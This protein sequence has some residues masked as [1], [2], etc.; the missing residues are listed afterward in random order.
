MKIWYIK[1]SPLLK[2]YM[3]GTVA[4]CSMITAAPPSLLAAANKP[5]IVAPVRQ[6]VTGKV[7]DAKDGSPLPGVNIM[8]KGTSKGT[9]TQPDGTFTLDAQPGD[10]L[11]L[12]LV[13]YTRQEIPAKNIAGTVIR[14]ESAATGL[15]ELIVVGYGAQKKKVVTGATVHLGNSDLVQNHSISVESSLQGQAPG[16]QVTSNSG[17]PGDALKIVIRGIGTN[18]DSRPLFIVDG[19]PADDI[20]YL[21]PS[22]IASLDILKDAASTAIYGTRAANGVVLIT[23]KRG[24]EGKMAVTLDASYGWQNPSR[25][26]SLLN[27][28]QFA[29]IMNEASINSGKV[30]VFSP[31]ALSKLGAGTDWQKEATLENAPIQ[32]YS[33]GFGG[34]NDKSV[35][36]ASLSYMGQQGIMGIAG[37]SYFERTSFRINSEHKV[38]E[39]RVKAGENLTYSHIRQSGIGTGN[40]YNNSIR[41]F[42]NASPVFP[43]YDSTGAYARSPMAADEV[44]P[45]GILDYTQNN[46]AITDRLLGNIYVDATIIKGLVFRSDFGI[47][48]SYVYNQSFVPVYELATNNSNKNSTASQGMYRNL[49]W[50][51]DN[52]LSYQRQFGKNNLN[53]M[54]GTTALLFDGYNVGGSAGDLIIPDMAHALLSNGTNDSLRKVFGMQEGNRMQSYFGRVLYNFDEKYM[55]TATLRRDG[56]SRFGADN[57]YGVF[58]GFSMGWVASNESFLKSEWLNFLKLRG[59]WGQNGNDRIR[60]FAY[61]ATISSVYRNY[62]FNNNKAIGSSPD[63]IANPGLRWERSEQTDIGFDATVFHD[64]NITFDWYR[65]VAKDWLVTAP[66]PQLAGTGAPTINGG[67]VRNTGVELAINYGHSFGDLRI[68]IG[69]NITYNKNEVMNIPNQ[70]GVLHPSYNGVLSSNMDEYYRAENGFPMGYFYGLQTAGIFQN[71]KEVDD[72]VGKNG[73]IQPG[74]QPGDVRFVDRNGDGVIDAK[75]KT[76]VGSPLP[77][78]TYGINLNASY[79]GF[80]LSILLNGVGGNQIVDGTR[81]YDR[82]YNNYTTDIFNRWHGEGT[83]NTTPRVTLGDEANGNYTKFSDLYVHNGAFMRVKSINL[84]YDLKSSLLK[85]SGLGQVRLYVSGLNLFTFTQYRGLD[86]EVGFGIDSW[87]SGTDLGYYPQARTLLVGLNVKF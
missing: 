45:M 84:G 79:K 52:T 48:L 55:L 67:S 54:V 57:R 3:L 16:V 2:Q 30:P 59:G 73:K 56:S 23:T 60:N 64:F 87:S 81:A 36:S 32:N 68:N 27:A 42:L 7:V 62:Y 49:K 76:K 61:L 69:G 39:D 46:K 11:V 34:G 28:T 41:G 26:M 19:F 72:Y 4:L 40:I 35:Y 14:L 6:P 53:V 25:K 77:T 51:W 50:N 65:K 78:H 29:S 70:E 9:I 1:S 20:N 85:H 63:I 71:Q 86:P 10:V 18:G 47:D 22:D 43:V 66:I 13:G 44:N 58:P 74:A 33:L 15:N 12:S 17:Q 21:N 80:D 37:R 83:S 8:I 24:K 5:V 31:D 82:F 75:D 38:W